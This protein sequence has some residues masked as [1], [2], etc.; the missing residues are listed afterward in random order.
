L[1]SSVSPAPQ[2][3]LRAIAD[4]DLRERYGASPKWLQIGGLAQHAAVGVVVVWSIARGMAEVQ[5]LGGGE[6]HWVAIREL[7]NPTEH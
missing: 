4:A 6:P 1:T 3:R 2:R 5:S 7:S